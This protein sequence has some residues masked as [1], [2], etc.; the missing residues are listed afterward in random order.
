MTG[1]AHARQRLRAEADAYWAAVRADDLEEALAAVDR[2]AAGSSPEEA[3]ERLVTAAQVRVGELWERG[4]WTVA[5]EHSAT[6]VSEAVVR[7]HLARA[8]AALPPSPSP[9][10][11][12]CAE[13]EWHALPGLLLAAALA[14]RG[15]PVVS[16]GADVSAQRLHG[17]LLDAPAA[18]VLVSASLSSS[19][20]RVRAHVETARLVGTPVVVGGHAFDAAGRRAEALGA[21]AQARDA[22][23]AADLV[24]TLSRHVE[25]APALTHEA[26]GEAVLL[27]ADGGR[28]V[29]QVRR[30]VLDRAGERGDLGPDRG[31]AD[32][33]R[34]VLDD[35]LPHVVGSLAGALLVRDI[36]VVAETRSWLST[37]L[38]SRS[39]PPSTVDDVWHAMH[40]TLHDFPHARALL[41][42]SGMA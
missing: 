15:L 10:V 30:S 26:V 23:G 42:R 4:E 33:W 27:E 16:L 31:A 1:A 41:E 32:R 11:V 39:A 29:D 40:R 17:S 37:V 36:G 8:Q 22:A 5:Q 6:A 35:Q 12:A 24:R 13:R 9:V 7:H 38:A 3:L 2:A 25:P 34:R 18:A 19:L 21:T 28:V 20:P 14:R